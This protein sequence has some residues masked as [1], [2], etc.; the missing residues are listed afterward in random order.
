[1]RFGPVPLAEAEGA[2]LAHRVDTAGGPL[3][4]GSLLDAAAVA[5]LAGA[6]LAEVIVA[7]LDPGEIGEDAAAAQ[8][9]AALAPDPAALG[10]RLTAAATGRVNLYAAGPGLFLPDAGRI[11]ALNRVHPMITLA[12]LPPFARVEP[13][14]MVA[15]AKIIAYGVPPVM[16]LYLVGLFW[17][18]ANAAG[19]TACIAT[20]VVAGIALFMAVQ[21][22]DL[23]SLHFLYIAPL[24]FIVC[25]VV[26]VV[27]SAATAPDAATKTEGIIWTPAFYREETARLAAE[28]FWRNYRVLAVGLLALTAAIVFTFR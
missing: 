17:R 3:A 6:G 18:R 1:M 7:R 28:P 10:L 19:A 16:A 15:T 24:L 13:R 4:K 20:G 12:T 27:V 21:V 2:I 25:A 14:S 5:R 9:A 11:A 8:L 26:L 22:L 23:F